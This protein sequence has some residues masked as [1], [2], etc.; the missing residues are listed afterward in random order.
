[1]PTDD[2]IFAIYEALKKGFSMDLIAELSGIDPFFIKKIERIVAF[3]VR[4]KEKFENN[5]RRAK[6]LGFSDERIAQI[7]GRSRME[8]SDLALDA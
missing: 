6:R 8:I 3:E 1:M 2:R 4:L 7:T 5:C